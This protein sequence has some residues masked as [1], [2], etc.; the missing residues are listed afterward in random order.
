[1]LQAYR[2]KEAD[3]GAKQAEYATVTAERDEVS[4]PLQH[5][6]SPL[7]LFDLCVGARKVATLDHVVPICSFRAA[8]SP[9][10]VVL[11]L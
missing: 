10:A 8:P 9:D 7:C 2:D 3:F 1:V 5:K 11:P 6:A 4:Q